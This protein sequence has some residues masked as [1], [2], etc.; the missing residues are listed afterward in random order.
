MILPPLYLLAE[1]LGLDSGDPHD[2]A[3]LDALAAP[4][5]RRLLAEADG[6]AAWTAAAPGRVA[7]AVDLYPAHHAD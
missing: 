4:P 7:T 6:A 2:D 5:A 3:A 1:L